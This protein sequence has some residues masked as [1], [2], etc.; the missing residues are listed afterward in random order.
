MKNALE[1]VKAASDYICDLN[2]KDGMAKWIEKEVFGQCTRRDSYDSI[3]N[4][5][6]YDS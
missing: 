2:D 6:A 4:E 5:A 1:E 3:K